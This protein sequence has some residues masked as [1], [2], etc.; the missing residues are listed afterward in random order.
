[1]HKSD[2][3]VLAPTD[4][5]GDQ[6]RWKTYESV[7]NPEAATP[8]IRKFQLFRSSSYRSWRRSYV[9][10]ALSLLHPLDVG[11]QSNVPEGLEQVTQNCQNPRNL[12]SFALLDRAHHPC[13]VLIAALQQALIG[14]LSSILSDKQEPIHTLGHT[15][16]YGC[17]V[18]R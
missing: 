18:A 16:Q 10:L 7:K 11:C 4:P 3:C 1:M 15:N 8:Q 14:C 13:R 12:C 17:D 5:P 9:P 2:Y 6:Q